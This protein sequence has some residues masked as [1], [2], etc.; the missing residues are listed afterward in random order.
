MPLAGVTQPDLYDTRDK[1]AVK[2]WPRFADKMIGTSSMFTAGGEARQ[3]AHQ[4]LLGM[5]KAHKADP[6]SN[7][8]WLNRMAFRPQECA[9]GSADP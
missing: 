4:S 8:E 6:N 2:K 9:H 5:D 1:C 3:D 7:R